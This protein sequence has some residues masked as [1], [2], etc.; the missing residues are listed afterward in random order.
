MDR[1][2][3]LILHPVFLSSVIL[4]FVNDHFLKYTFHN[5]LTGK[6]SDFAGLIAL[7]LLIAYCIP[8]LTKYAC[9]IAALWFM[10][11]KMPI[12]E[13]FIQL[14]RDV[15]HVNVYRTI[16]YSDFI[17]LL[18]III[19][20]KLL[21]SPNQVFIWNRALLLKPLIAI[22]SFITL[23]ATSVPRYMYPTRN[24]CH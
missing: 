5:W 6:L 2:T 16:D 18:V 7:P 22:F 13:S 19:P 4:L 10:Y 24:T 8:K 12:S 14:V 21:Q 9:L 3:N 15:T 11:W 20:M 17:A 1:K 23:A